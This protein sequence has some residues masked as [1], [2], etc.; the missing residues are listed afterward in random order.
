MSPKR[1][2][3]IR[4]AVL[5]AGASV[6]LAVAGPASAS[7]GWSVESTPAGHGVTLN[8]V[9]CTS[10]SRCVA[11]GGT[12]AEGWNGSTW[13]ALPAP[14][15]AGDLAA[16]ACPSAALCIA[17][18]SNTSHRAAAWS[19]NGSSWTTRSAYNPSSA[20]N[21][22]SAIKCASATSC[23]AVG[24]HGNG[25]SFDFPLAEFWNGTTWAD[26][27]TAG[28]PD[29]TLAGVSC[30]SPASCEAVGS[31]DA[32]SGTTTLAMHWNGSKWSTQATPVIP[33]QFDSPPGEP[34]VFSGVSCWASG[35][36]AVGTTYYCDCSPESSG[37]ILLAEHWNGSKWALEGKLGTGVSPSFNS[38]TWN[39]VHCTSA[40]ACT[41]AGEWT[42]DNEAQPYETLI[43]QWNGSKWSQV[44]SPSPN[45]NGDLLNGI[46]CTSTACTAVGVQGGG[47]SEDGNALAMRN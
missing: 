17:V 40:S 26:Q 36:M 39:A 47:D 45:G 20:D 29:G 21:T 15:G 5:A 6:V 42:E 19:W 25:S 11:V 7:G 44:T 8:G 32:S 3:M 27:S 18:G 33:D 28:A 46:G 4:S 34:Y 30:E 24:T 1:E 10:A 22:L 41:A 31:A 16:I 38:A 43:S 35:C 13:A 9:A 2:W 12:H 37:F 14:A 23:E